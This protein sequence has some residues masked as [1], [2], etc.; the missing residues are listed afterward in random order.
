LVKKK[1][2]DFICSIVAAVCGNNNSVI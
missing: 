1:H 2:G